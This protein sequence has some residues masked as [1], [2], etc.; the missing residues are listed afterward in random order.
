M[1]LFI[2]RVKSPIG[3]I[4]II[5]DGENLRALDFED[6]EER[7]EK[8][9]KRHYG[10][11][12]LVPQK[13]PNGVSEVMERYFAGELDAIDEV[14]VAANGT[15]FQTA[16][17]KQLRNVPLGKTWSYGELARRVGKPKAS[18]AVGLANGSN[19]IAIVV[20]CHRVIGANGSLTGYGGGMERKQWLL[21]HEGVNLI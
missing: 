11:Y 6:Y 17:W 8:L 15:Q 1:K 18:R 3:E 9:L 4:R 21:V 2:D 7:M 10:E 16:V 12:E 14:K 5:S 20:P 13:N 19:P